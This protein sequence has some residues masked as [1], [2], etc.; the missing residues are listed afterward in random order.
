LRLRNNQHVVNAD[1]RERPAI[2][3]INFDNKKGSIHYTKS[4]ASTNRGLDLQILLMTSNDRR[5]FTST[6]TLFK[7]YYPGRDTLSLSQEKCPAVNGQRGKA[8]IL[9]QS[10]HY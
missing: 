8:T 10:A 7:Q 2:V 4:A 1:S 5:L 9:R 6:A 3:L